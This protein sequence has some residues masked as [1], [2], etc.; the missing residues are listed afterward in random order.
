MQDHTL[1][2]YNASG[3]KVNTGF[4]NAVIF[5]II[6]MQVPGI[7]G[8]WQNFLDDSRVYFSQ[9][10]HKK[11]SQ[12]KALSVSPLHQENIPLQL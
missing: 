4:L 10:S 8:M 5:W 9:T 6:L 3:K 11:Y 2:T 7:W 1:T 12:H